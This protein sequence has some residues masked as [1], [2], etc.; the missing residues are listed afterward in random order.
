MNIEL[1]PNN[2]G[3]YSSGGNKMKGVKE[4]IRDIENKTII[5]NICLILASSG[6][7]R[8]KKIFK[9]VIVENCHKNLE[10]HSVYKQI[11]K[12]QKQK[13]YT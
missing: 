11:C 6:R 10:K 1:K 12:K 9:H 5:Y 13:H 3:E 4:K 8:I 7:N 2:Y